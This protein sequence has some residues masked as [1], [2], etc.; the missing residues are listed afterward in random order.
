MPG[1]DQD[2]VAGTDLQVRLLEASR[3]LVG[4]DDVSRRQPVP[5]EERADVEQQATRE[6]DSDVLDAELLEAV[7]ISELG[8][9]VPVIKIVLAAHAD[10]DV[11]E[12]IE[13]GP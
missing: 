6:E 13:L 5:A 10:A 7:R 9:L 4:R 1:A 11:A 8:Q 2:D 3:Q 12:S